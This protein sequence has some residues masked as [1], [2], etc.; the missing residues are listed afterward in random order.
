VITELEKVKIQRVSGQHKRVDSD[1]V[2]FEAE[3]LF[4]L[5]GKNY[6]SFYCSPTRLEEMARGYLISEGVCSLSGIG[7][8]ESRWDGE[9]FVVEATIDGGGAKLSEINS[10]IKINTADIWAM[11][12]KLNE[13]SILFAK[14]GGTH[15]VGIF[16]RCNSVFAEDVSRHCA[17]DKAIGLACQ[18]GVRLTTGVLVVSCRQTESTIRKAVYSRIP[19]VI[20]TSAVSSLAI[21]S[22]HKY[23]ITLIGFARE[24]RFNIY[25]HKER[26]TGSN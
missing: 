16:S 21:E 1:V 14:T 6:R 3:V 4:K 24:H 15:V 9:R 18:K 2:I 11:V 20:S 8:I 12:E 10:A 26:I 22:A 13:R 19:I 23:D 25:A 17:I 7:D 5:N